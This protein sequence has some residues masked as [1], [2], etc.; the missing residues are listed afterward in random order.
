[1]PASPEYR[2]RYVPCCPPNLPLAIIL[3]GMLLSSYFL[4]LVH[5]VIRRT[6][7]SPGCTPAGTPTPSPPT[8]PPWREGELQLPPRAAPDI[9]LPCGMP[10]TWRGLM[11]GGCGSSWWSGTHL[12][13]ICGNNCVP[14]RR[15]AE[16]VTRGAAEGRAGNPMPAREAV[17]LLPCSRVRAL[18]ER[19][20]RPAGPHA[21]LPLPPA[22]VRGRG[23][24]AVGHGDD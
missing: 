8:T 12:S 7:A 14:C 15:G 6:P 11:R 17:G 2:D 5:P 22:P 16:E 9:S 1:M 18:P 23:R 4:C 10:V 13:A 3:P 19:H 21:R 24:A 20:N